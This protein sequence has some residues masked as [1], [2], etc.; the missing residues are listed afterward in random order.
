MIGNQEEH[1]KGSSKR[2]S[3][4]WFFFSSRNKLD[5]LFV[6]SYVSMCICI[7]QINN[8]LL[9]GAACFCRHTTCS[10]NSISESLI[11]LEEKTWSSAT[12]W[13]RLWLRK[14]WRYEEENQIVWFSSSDVKSHLG[15]VFFFRCLISVS[16]DFMFLAFSDVFRRGLLEVF[17][18]LEVFFKRVITYN[19]VEDH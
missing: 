5:H 11:R 3:F 12:L 4:V 13:L 10:K 6:V 15:L 1:A 17:C 14:M 7:D 18:L 8:N 19:K 9:D 2:R 16:D